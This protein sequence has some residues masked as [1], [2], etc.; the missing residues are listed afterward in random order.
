MF[1]LALFMI[2]KTWKQL[3]YPSWINGS[4]CGVYIMGC[5]AARKKWENPVIC[6]NISGPRRHY[7]R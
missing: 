6:G 2:I 3:K 5:Y 1:E 7:T 4:S